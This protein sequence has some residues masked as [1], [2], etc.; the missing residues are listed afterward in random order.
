MES[1]AK[2]RWHGRPSS[3]ELE[4][5]IEVDIGGYQERLARIIRVREGGFLKRLMT[6]YRLTTRA[7][8]EMVRKMT[9]SDG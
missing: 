5:F 7:I 3:R 6:L 4:A 8:A 9:A 2:S 1:T